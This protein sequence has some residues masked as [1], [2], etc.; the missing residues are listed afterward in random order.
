LPVAIVQTT[1]RQTPCA[2]P[3][4]RP[5]AA[6]AA[7]PPP[8]GRRCCALAAAFRTAAATARTVPPP[9][10]VPPSLRVP[11]RAGGVEQYAVRAFADALDDVPMALAENSG[12]SPIAELGAVKAAQMAQ[13]SSSLGIDC[14][15]EGTRDMKEQVRCAICCAAVCH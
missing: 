8:P 10:P 5:S 6:A 1:M 4:T 11:P 12:L 2:Q 9:P 7:L 14:N 15:Q 13:R 3:L